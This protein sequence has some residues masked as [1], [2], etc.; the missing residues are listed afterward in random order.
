MVSSNI[1]DSVPSRDAFAE[2]GALLRE[3]RTTRDLSLEDVSRIVR[4]RPD[5]LNSLE[6]AK[7]DNLPEKVYVRGF[8]KAYGNYL[9]LDGEALA[10]RFI[11][12]EPAGIRKRSRPNNPVRMQLRP[13]HAWMAYVALI[14]GAV[15]GITAFLDR[16]ES[17]VTNPS[18]SPQVSSDAQE[19]G[20][21]SHWE[22]DGESLPFQSPS[23]W[24]YIAGVF[25]KREDGQMAADAK[26]HSTD[27]GLTVGIQVLEAAS[28]ARVV[29]DRKTV[30]EGLLQPG[31]AQEWQASES[32]AI[33]V[34]NAGGVRL[35]LNDEELGVMG[36]AGE[37]RERAF[38]L[39]ED[40][41]IEVR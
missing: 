11:T 12:V 28:W 9:G 21:E 24:T 35:S 25:P 38:W 33:R 30:F 22:T 8:I 32:L 37:V 3:A 31:V 14:V 13:F 41:S 7:L 4:I 26:S 36:E 18:A 27:G 23:E 34:G 15:G 20:L 2:I 1:P 6:A 10:R 29:A 5:F 39:G 40:G 16:N 19:A 17:P